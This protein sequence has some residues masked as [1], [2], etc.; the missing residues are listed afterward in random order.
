MAAKLGLPKQIA[1]Q[2]CRVALNALDYKYGSRKEQ[3]L[4]TLAHRKRRVA[5]AQKFLSWTEADWKKV[6]FMDE[7]GSDSSRQG[8]PCCWMPKD[9]SKPANRNKVKSKGPRVNFSVASGW[10]VKLKL[11]TYKGGLD[12]DRFIDLCEKQLKPFFRKNPS[13]KYIVMDGDKCHPGMGQRSSKKVN[14]YWLNDPIL[15]KVKLLAGPDKW[16]KDTGAPR[17]AAQ[18]A[19]ALALGRNKI[20]EAPVLETWPANSPELNIAEHDVAAIKQDE[21]WGPG[22]YSFDEMVK[23]YKKVYAGY[24]QDSINRAVLSMPARLQAVIKKDGWGITHTD[25]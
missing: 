22:Q 11:Y 18:Q 8:P 21:D 15:K 6:L 25:Y 24:S 20:P 23:T 14:K 1:R 9:G 5:F 16:D 19:K 17:T 3:C 12:S 13:F 7:G 10:N 4:L 2:Y